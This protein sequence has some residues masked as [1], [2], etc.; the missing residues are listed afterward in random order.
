MLTNN[1]I[2][3]FS[4]QGEIHHCPLSELHQHLSRDETVYYNRDTHPKIFAVLNAQEGIQKY[5]GFLMKDNTWLVPVSNATLAALKNDTLSLEQFDTRHA[6]YLPVGSSS[7]IDVNHPLSKG[8]ILSRCKR[9]K[10]DF[11]SESVLAYQAAITLNHPATQALSAEK[12]Q[13][14]PSSTIE[15]K[16]SGEIVSEAELAEISAK[17]AQQ[18]NDY[19]KTKAKLDA[20]LLKESKPKQSEV[21]VIEPLA[22][23]ASVVSFFQ[24]ES[25]SPMAKRSSIKS[26]NTAS[27]ASP[28]IPRIPR[29]K[30]ALF[31]VVCDVVTASI[32]M[33]KS[34][35]V[36]RQLSLELNDNDPLSIRQVSS[37]LTNTP[38]SPGLCFPPEYFQH[39]QGE[40]ILPRDPTDREIQKMEALLLKHNIS[41]T[42]S[43]IEAVKQNH[44][45]HTIPNT[46]EALSGF[47]VVL[48]DIPESGLIELFHDRN[49]ANLHCILMWLREMEIEIT[50]ARVLSIT[51][52]PNLD[53][54]THSLYQL[55][56]H[57]LLNEL[58]ISWAISGHNRKCDNT[59]F[60]R[61][62]CDR[63]WCLVDSDSF[64][65]VNT[66][67]E[68]AE[69]EDSDFANVKPFSDESFFRADSFSAPK[70][71]ESCEAGS[72]HALGYG[73]GN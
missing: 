71:T 62:T 3:Y 52:S 42:D 73:F 11:T 8:W 28:L 2:F 9:P 10:E 65:S 7:S 37:R 24:T 35:T 45:L 1:P 68:K 54:L 56:T 72:P 70:R 63:A 51:Q 20:L 44:F 12:D 57:Q 34:E 38:H 30:K 39:E 69:Y 40:P 60:N 59:A 55:K 31:A 50:P 48:S 6:T 61:A 19:E 47:A 32:R 17:R 67:E 49:F 16:T 21:E 14:T 58:S 15:D 26:I 43:V 46:L 18:K 4:T 33:K 23:R 66:S 64:D 13:H 5:V 27:N 29:N 53:M 22:R 36:P 41:L 25:P